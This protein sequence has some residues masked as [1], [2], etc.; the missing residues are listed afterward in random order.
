MTT[1]RELIVAPTAGG[2]LT[3]EG[4]E[5][6]RQQ[7]AL[8][9]NFVKSVL[10]ENQ[11]Y[12][13]IPGTQG[14]RTLLKPGAANIIAAFNCHVEPVIESAIVDPVKGYVA[15][16]VRCDI[17]SNLHGQ[18]MARGFGEANSYE[19]KWRYRNAKA[20]CPE[21]GQEA[22]IKGK[23]E[24]GGGWLCFKKLGGCGA[25]FAAEAPEITDQKVGKVENENPLD[26][27]NTIKKIAVKRATTDAALQLPGVARFFTQDF[28]DETTAN[29]DEAH[30]PATRA[31][32]KGST[33]PAAPPAEAKRSAVKSVSH[34]FAVWAKGLPLSA[35]TVRNKLGCTLTEYLQA[36][37][38]AEARTALEKIM[39]EQESQ[40]H[41]P[42]GLPAAGA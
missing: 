29:E 9:E 28:D 16:E 17:I 1:G 7:L 3:K 8:L 22:I 39:R 21:C 30:P 5:Q 37:S 18:L 19:S 2:A 38:E 41:G 24:Y 12:G 35:E 40:A 36:H 26:L 13:V 25:K 4:L 27:A 33:A 32:P 34:E 31:E 42:S 20:Q 10:R 23:A 15:Y 11:D 6:T 14:K